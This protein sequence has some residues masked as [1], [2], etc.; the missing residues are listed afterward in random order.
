MLLY[1]NQGTS[2]AWIFLEVLLQFMDGANYTPL[3]VR[4][5]ANGRGSTTSIVRT[6]L[7]G[8]GWHVVNFAVVF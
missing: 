7:T 8:T 4:G 3:C 1:P 2:E 6:S 5:G